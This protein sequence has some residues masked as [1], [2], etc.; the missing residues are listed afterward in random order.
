[1]VIARPAA[2]IL[3]DSAIRANANAGNGGNILIAADILIPSAYSTIDA[4][5]RT[6]ID[7]QVV[8]D[9]PNQAISSVALLDAP[10]YD[11]TGLVQDP[12]EVEVL[13]APLDVMCELQVEGDTMNVALTWES[14]SSY[15]RAPWTGSPS[16]ELSAT[17]TRGTTASP[18]A[19]PISRPWSSI[20]PARP[21]TTRPD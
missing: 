20:V 10:V 14:S 6:G 15:G 9:S 21:S 8:I 4:S 12:C 5:S 16:P 19:S 3:N 17:S 13:D 11:V 7:G 1:M 2:V 18:T